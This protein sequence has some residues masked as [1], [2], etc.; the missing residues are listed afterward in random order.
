F[1]LRQRSEKVAFDVD[2]FGLKCGFRTGTPCTQ[3]AAPRT[4]YSEPC[5]PSAAA[6]PDGLIH[7]QRVRTTPSEKSCESSNCKSETGERTI[8]NF[9]LSCAAAC[10]RLSMRAPRL[11]RASRSRARGLST[12]GSRRPGS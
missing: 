12:L 9:A 5:V 1:H 3:S 6:A 4:D 10:D 7:W 11:T 2:F 8:R